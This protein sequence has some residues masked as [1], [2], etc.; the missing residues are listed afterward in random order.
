MDA[1]GRYVPLDA[2]ASVA[3]DHPMIDRAEALLRTAS[4]IGKPG[5]F[6]IE[7]AIQSAHAQRRV[8]GRVEWPVVAALYQL[9][10]TFTPALGAHIGHAIAT[11][12]ASGPEQ[13]LVLLESLPEERLADHQPYWAARAHLLAQIGRT[14][15]AKAAFERAIGL[16]DDP[17]VR[18]YLWER[19][20]HMSSA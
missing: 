7:A 4:G 14:N 12:H 17:A 10:M 6:Q 2:Q 13:G 11:A 8:T 9:L 5:R 3:W 1:S 18:V 20:Q 16:C 15:E 19:L